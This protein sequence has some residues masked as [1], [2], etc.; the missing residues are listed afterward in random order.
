MSGGVDSAVSLLRAAPN[1]IGVTLRLW[2][3]PAGPSAE[4]ACCSPAAVSAAR[5]TC[6]ALGVPH[7]TLD[8]REEFRAGS[9]HRSSPRTVRGDAEPVHALQRRFPVRRLARV[10]VA[11]WCREALDRP[12]RA[13]RRA[14]GATLARARSRPAEG[15]VVHAGDRRPRASRPRRVSARRP[16]EGRDARRGHP[17]R[18]TRSFPARE[19]G[20]VLPR[21][22]R[23]PPVPRTTGCRLRR[24]EVVDESGAIVGR[25]D[26]YWRFTPGQRRGL[27]IAA[28][29][30]LYVLRTD[31]VSNQVT[32]GAHDALA[33]SRVDAE[34]V[35][36]APV[37]R[38]AAKLRYR[39]E[40]V[41]AAVSPTDRGFSLEL[42]QPSDAVAHGPDR[43]S[44]RR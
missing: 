23:L 3:D 42:E 39:S 20:G 1:A 11:S 13:D 7:V 31:P 33:A 16:V 41:F 15:S 4:R 22:R 37:S 35:L 34:G 6:H 18:V 2:Q 26:G 44:L 40:P 24:G 8:L 27:G 5:A 10:H 14:R 30:P 43:R 36:Y 21:G 12:L 29:R 19:S 32:V 25:H 28:A 38:A 17:R 9:S